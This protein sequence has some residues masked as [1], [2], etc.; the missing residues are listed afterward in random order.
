MRIEKHVWYKFETSFHFEFQSRVSFLF[1]VLEFS[2]ST[3][4]SFR[5]IEVK[6]IEKKKTKNYLSTF[7]EN[8]VPPE[9][10]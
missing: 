5:E 2:D 1:L 4:S 10:N 6:K 9:N 3:P 8:G 7:F